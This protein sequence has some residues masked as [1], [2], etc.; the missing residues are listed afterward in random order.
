LA[1]VMAAA[2]FACTRQPAPLPAPASG[3]AAQPVTPPNA[4]NA[5]AGTLTAER[6]EP[7]SEVLEARL[8][9]WDA[10][11]D[12]RN[13]FFQRE[14]PDAKRPRLRRSFS[15][16][17]IA[18]A[19]AYAYRTVPEL[20]WC[21]SPTE[22]PVERDGRICD[23]VVAPGAVLDAAQLQGVLGL[24]D[25]AIGR[26]RALQKEARA[27]GYTYHGPLTRCDFD[28]HHTV[29]FY[30]EAGA[31][32]GGLLVCFSCSDWVVVPSHPDLQK[33]MSREERAALHELF[34]ALGLGSRSFDSDTRNELFEYR[35][36]VYGTP[37]NE[38]TEA[39]KL[40]QTRRI[41]L[42]S[43]IDPLAP[44]RG[45]TAVQRLRSCTWFHHEL[46]VGGAYAHPGSGYECVDRRTFRLREHSVDQCAAVKLRCDATAGQIESCLAA[47]LP[48][49]AV[50]CESPGLPAPCKDVIGCLP[51][52]EWDPQAGAKGK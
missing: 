30:D 15:T 28:P 47:L 32:I 14:Q 4:V 51:E 17:G 22:L 49:P 29:L 44:A 23:E 37:P 35:G 20:G 41:A 31:V 25:S 33:L 38:L 45:L 13:A 10:L 8:E 21:S 9:T 19:R 6:T 52:L 27:R 3:I 18:S 36:R 50:L 43:G 5:D 1:A 7:R 26:L 40:Q 48:T 46:R 42:R 39:G 11:H 34:E 12:F 16:K 2:L 24:L